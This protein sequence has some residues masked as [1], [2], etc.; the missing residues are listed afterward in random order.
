MNLSLYFKPGPMITTI[1]MSISIA[2]LVLL[3]GI[4]S[5]AL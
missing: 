2:P 4:V 3:L 5:A 1:I